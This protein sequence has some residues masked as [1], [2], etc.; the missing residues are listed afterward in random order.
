MLIHFW[1]FWF[2]DDLIRS[3]THGFLGALPRLARHDVYNTSKDAAAFG[4]TYKM[5]VFNA[6]KVISRASVR[7]QEQHG[8]NGARTRGLTLRS[9]ASVEKNV[10]LG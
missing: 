2:I 5:A 1:Y 4:C 7:H 10:N 3:Y 8:D 9:P 6:S